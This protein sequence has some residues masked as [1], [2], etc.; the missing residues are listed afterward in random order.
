MRCK[1]IA[2]VSIAL[3]RY[4][5]WM[6]VSREKR[7]MDWCQIERQQLILSCFAEHVNESD[8]LNE[9]TS[10]STH[11]HHDI[12]L[13][14]PILKQRKN[15]STIMKCHLST[16]PEEMCQTPNKTGR[17]VQI[18]NVSS[19]SILHFMSP[20]LIPGEFYL[21]DLPMRT[22]ESVL[23]LMA[24]QQEEWICSH[25]QWYCMQSVISSESHLLKDN[26]TQSLFFLFTLYSDRRPCNN[27]TSLQNTIDVDAINDIT[28]SVTTN[29]NPID[30]TINNGQ[31]SKLSHW[32]SH[33]TWPLTQYY[34]IDAHSA[35]KP[36]EYFAKHFRK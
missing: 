2:V 29:T 24:A 13:S 23:C 7:I 28:V 14:P 15:G 1:Y 8:I 30:L 34:R 12:R 36:P 4:R 16:H 18:D 22:A 32:L 11:L 35:T 19:P 20:T 21:V 27:G 5:I 3:I 33:L 6:S 31:S 9:L 26:A 17:F 25:P 10:A